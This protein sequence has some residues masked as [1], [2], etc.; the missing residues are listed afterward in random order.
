[1]KYNGH[2]FCSQN[3]EYFLHKKSEVAKLWNELYKKLGVSFKQGIDNCNANHWLNA[4]ILENSQERDYFLK[5]TNEKGVMCRPIWELM[6]NLSM[7][8]NSERADL[9]NSE[10][11]KD[12]VVNI[13]S[14]VPSDIELI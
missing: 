9:K 7:F 11:L 12:R 1:M 4:I 6:T 5:L 3:N 2:L 14:S 10:W 8:S 13:P